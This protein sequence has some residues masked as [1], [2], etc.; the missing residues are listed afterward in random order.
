MSFPVLKNGTYFSE[1]ITCSPVR[2]L[3]PVRAGRFFTENAPKPRSSTR[4]PRDS[5]ATTSSRMAFTM[6][7]TSRWNRCGLRA[8][9]RS[10]SS[11]L[12]T[13]AP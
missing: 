3:R 4:S 7:S 2:G 5:A 9:M 11:D 12:I 13:L 6:C 1:T 8:A 10:M